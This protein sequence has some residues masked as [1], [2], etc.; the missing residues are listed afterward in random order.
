MDIESRFAIQDLLGKAAYALDG[1]DMSMLRTCFSDDA[2]FEIRM[3]GVPE[4]MAFSGN[5]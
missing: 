4:E 2:E 5:R 1:H 3:E